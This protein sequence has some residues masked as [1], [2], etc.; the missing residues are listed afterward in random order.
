M[1]PAFHKS[2]RKGRTEALQASCT[3]REDVLYTDAAEYEIK[4][5]QTA[6]A[7][8]EVGTLMACCTDSGVETG[9]VE[10]VA[11]ALAVSEKGSGGDQRLRGRCEK[12]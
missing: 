4:P 12:L 9:E 11:I 2:I 3:G 5:A 8:K 7:A 1:N 6:V 10:E